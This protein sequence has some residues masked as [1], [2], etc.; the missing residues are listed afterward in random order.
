VITAKVVPPAAR[1]IVPL[2]VVLTW[3]SSPL[4]AAATVAEP[5]EVMYFVVFSL[6]KIKSSL[7]SY[8][9]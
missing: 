6:L 7:E 4:A 5:L 2:R 3:I 9:S 8:S 1:V